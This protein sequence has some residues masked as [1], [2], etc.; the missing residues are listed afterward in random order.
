M[1][2]IAGIGIQNGCTIK[3]ASLVRSLFANL[4]E[5]TMIRGYDATGAAYVSREDINVI[6]APTIASDMVS[7]KEFELANSSY[8]NLQGKNG[9]ISTI[10][11][12]RQETKGTYK[13]NDNNHPIITGRIVGVH[14]GVIDNDDSIFAA[15]ENVITRKGEVD[16]EVIFRLLDYMISETKLDMQTALRNMYGMLYGSMACAF[17]DRKNPYLL[18]LFRRYGQMSIFHYNECGLVVFASEDSIIN[19]ATSYPEY[20]NLG[21]PKVIFLPAERALCI[22]LYSNTMWTFELEDD[23]ANYRKAGYMS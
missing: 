13:N 21:D 8:L 10:G 23:I 11:H 19:N 1:C 20:G 5:E 9:T 22:N 4:L 12:C 6:K 7:S 3:D 18:W 15:Y 16:S 2:G 14:N 17:V